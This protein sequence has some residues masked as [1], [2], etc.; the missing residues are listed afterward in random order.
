[1][2]D[3]PS[4]AP[5]AP[6]LPVE[7]QSV[8][9][10]AVPQSPAQF[11][12]Q[13]FA[14]KWGDEI[15]PHTALLVTLDYDY[16]GHPPRNGL[17]QG[18]VAR[19]NTLLRALLENYQVVGD[20]RFAETAF[21]LYTPPDTGPAVQIAEGVDEFAQPGSGNHRT[22]EGIYR[23]CMP[24]T[25]GPPTQLTLRPADFKRW[26][27]TLELKE[28]Y[29]AYLD[30]VWPPDATILASASCPLRT[31]V[32]AA[33][34]MSA[35]L[36]RDE[37]SL[38]QQGLEQVLQTA[39][40]PVNQAWS[41]L[42]LQQ[43][44]SPTRVPGTFIFGRL[45]I[46]R[47][48]A[49]DIWCFR[50][51]HPAKILLYLP[52]NASPWHEFYDVAQM[53]RWVV[54]Q[55]RSDETKNA[56]AS[57]FVEDDR[58]DGTF[59]AGVLTAL[60]GMVRYPKIHWL[61]KTAGFFNNDGY[62]NPTEYIDFESAAASTDPVAQM[63]L[64]MKRTAQTSAE[65]IRDDAQVNRDNLGDF[66][67]PLVQ[68]I[69]R[70]APLALFV[71]GGEG[72][73]A[74]AGLIDAGYGLEQTMHG[75]TLS[76]RSRGRART[77]F[78]LL[79][80][81]PLVTAVAHISN[82][83]TAPE[84]VSVVPPEP[85]KSIT[86]ASGS[87]VQLLRGIGSEVQ[88]FSDATLAQI[89]RVSAIDDDMLRAMN[90]GRPPTPM[91]ADTLSRFRLD[92]ELGAL[93]GVERAAQFNRRYLASQASDNPWVNLFQQE[94]PGLPKGVVEQVL[95]RYGVDLTSMPNAAEFKRLLSRLD[96]KGR[97]Y[98]QHVRLNR[99]YEGLYLRSVHN[100]DSDLLI[101]HSLPRLPGWP[102]GLRIEVLD[103]ALDGRVVDRCGPLEATQVR[104]L[105]RTTGHEYSTPAIQ[106]PADMHAALLSLLC[107]PERA[108]LQVTSVEDFKLR[109]DENLLP[110]E[111]LMTGLGRMD[112]GLPFESQGLRGGGYPSTPQGQA[113]ATEAMRL[114]LR[115]LYPALNPGQVDDWLMRAGANAQ[116]HI[117]LLRKQFDQLCLDVS[118]YIEGAVLD[119][120][121]LDVDFLAAGDPAA[122]GLTPMQIQ[123]HNIERLREVVRYERETREELAYELLTLWQN[124][125]AATSH[126]FENGTLAGYRLDLEFEDFHRLPV[127][128]VRLNDV[129][130]LSMRG[131]HLAHSEMLAGFL[132]SFPRLRV[133]N[134]EQV[135]LR[136]PDSTGAMV[137]VLPSV[138]TQ[139][140]QLRTLN[141]R[142]TSLRLDVG[143]SS[144]NE[145]VNLQSLDLS[146][147]PLGVPPILLGMKRLREVNLRSTGIR[148]CPIGISDEPVLT[149]LDL[150]DNQISRV[151]PAVISQA[152][153]AGRVKLQGNPLTDED[154]L[155]RLII[156]RQET[157]FNLWLSG[158]E[159]GQGEAV[160][161]LRGIDLSKQQERLAIWQRLAARPSGRGV[162]RTLE[163]LSLTPD[164]LVDYPALQARVWRLLRA[165]DDSDEV[166]GRLSQSVESTEV[167][168]DNPM[169]ILSMLEQRLQNHGE[170]A[171]LSQAGEDANTRE[172]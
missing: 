156:H 149:L 18:R 66:V 59:H 21:G 51:Q 137:G 97:Q 133:L 127:M 48:T 56:L 150:R 141:L 100:P 47:Y 11:A 139:M 112:S 57:H 54:E 85:P 81:L 147:N 130:E 70:Y 126:V 35:W 67:E 36:Q 121:E 8:V 16:A 159:N 145:L 96:S 30:Q 116:A 155:R 3:L 41:T 63:V 153:V 144:L 132:N 61:S 83:L 90:E 122:E 79:N 19:S 140:H 119:A 113:L 111:A 60:D 103:A 125:P 49:T 138:I 7:L 94:Y 17:H 20:G 146:E 114:Q 34:V 151:P 31:S 44:Q 80:A 115:D 45:E 164:Y 14:H 106:S 76:E 109:I 28:K 71:P 161:W 42:T 4:T 91:L 134:L 99:A 160:A 9:S 148:A 5:I 165:A 124:R 50:G 46:Y 72:V 23:Q 172:A 93:T 40:L 43:L 39:G 143:T 136:L 78:G 86:V 6:A 162:L 98:Q 135:D 128:N 101:L 32:K 166:L 107:A 22:Y 87:R 12:A 2:N 102:A 82:D 1:M 26:V 92:Q 171:V 13:L 64:S 120:D 62:W 117:D 24:Q 68:W 131:F 142:A 65:S 158:V 73:L 52:G 77:V 88:G 74:L 29:Q 69:N 170:S 75:E 108:A 58:T 163:G 25:F 89:A 55:G 169:A 154:T 110:R 33:F 118:D 152:T 84:P 27:W 15:D 123:Q 129:I 53:R 105:I 95:D 38:S 167:G 37:G 168:A 10:A 157:G 104:R